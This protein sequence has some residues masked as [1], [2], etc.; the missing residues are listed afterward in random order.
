MLRERSCTFPG[1][2]LFTSRHVQHFS[3][4]SVKRIHESLFA[5]V[6]HEK[7]CAHFSSCS[8]ISPPKNHGD[9]LVSDVS[10]QC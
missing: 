9:L 2:S 4:A 7:R 5:R 10:N 3:R 8:T 1:F 6:I